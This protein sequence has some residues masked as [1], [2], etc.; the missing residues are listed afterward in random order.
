MTRQEFKPKFYV[1]V[2]IKLL[3]LLES[4]FTRFILTV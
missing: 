2:F 4:R 1:L 3:S